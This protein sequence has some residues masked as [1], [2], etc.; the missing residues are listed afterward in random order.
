MTIENIKYFPTFNSARD[1]SLTHVHGFPAKRVVETGEY[2]YIDLNPA[3]NLPLSDRVAALWIER[4]GRPL[5]AKPSPQAKAAHA[6][7]YG[8]TKIKLKTK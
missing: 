1:F 3:L 6:H 5:K 7:I 4:G 2:F 8:S